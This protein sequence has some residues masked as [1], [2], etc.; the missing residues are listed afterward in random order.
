MG[1][2][3]DEV[4]QDREKRSI[5]IDKI[6]TLEIFDFFK[7]PKERL[8]ERLIPFGCFSPQEALELWKLLPDGKGNFLV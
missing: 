5:F 2:A 6:K 1:Q 3:S 7:V 8:Q 4:R